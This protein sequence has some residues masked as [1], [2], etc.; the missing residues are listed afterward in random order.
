MWYSA[1]ESEERD[2]KDPLPQKVVV[3]NTWHNKCDEKSISNPSFQ[4]PIKNGYESGTYKCD[5]CD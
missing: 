4:W 2:N 3:H 5:E 1:H